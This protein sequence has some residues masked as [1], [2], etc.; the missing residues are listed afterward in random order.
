MVQHYW[1]SMTS[2]KSAEN[3]TKRVAVVVV[4]GIA[5]QKPNES[6]QAI[7]NLLQHKWSPYPGF[8]P[9]RTLGEEEI[10]IP[11]RKI[12]VDSADLEKF[13]ASSSRFWNPILELIRLSERFF[14][15][16][17]QEFNQSLDALKVHVS[18][19]FKSKKSARRS[20]KEAH[21]KGHQILD[22][23]H[24]FTRDQ[25][26]KYVVKKDYEY[27][28]SIRVK[29][30]Q[31]VSAE[32]VQID[33]HEM[34]WADL[35]RVGKGFINVFGKF[36]QLLF[37]I[38]SL[39]RQCIDF[40]RYEDLKRADIT[41]QKADQ[42][43]KQALEQK[44]YQKLEREIQK[45]KFWMN[46]QQRLWWFYSAVQAIAGR[47]LTLVIPILN[48]FV[49]VAGLASL[50]GLIPYPDP[51]FPPTPPVTP[52][53][54]L[55]PWI[56]IGGMCLVLFATIGNRVLTRNRL[57]PQ[58]WATLFLFGVGIPAILGSAYLN[59]HLLTERFFILCLYQTLA[60]VWSVVLIYLLVKIL[61]IPYNKHRKGVIGMTTI[62]GFITAIAGFWC[63]FSASSS[64]D[65][66]SRHHDVLVLGSLKLIE[67]L[68]LELFLAWAAFLLLY[69][70]SF[71]LGFVTLLLN[72]CI[73]TS[74]CHHQRPTFWTLYR[75]TWTARLSLTLPAILFSFL[76]LSLW[77]AI[78]SPQVGGMVLPNRAFYQ[79]L[80]LFQLSTSITPQSFITC[81]T[82]FS[83]SAV[84]LLIVSAVAILL[85]LTVWA[86]L[87]SFWTEYK[88][89]QKSEELFTQGLGNWLTS[90]YMLVIIGIEIILNLGIPLL[91]IVGTT[92]GAYQLLGLQLPQILR[93]LSDGTAC[94]V[95]DS[96]TTANLLNWVAGILVASA[97]GLI[98]FGNRLDILAG[99]VQNILDL[100]LDVDNYLRSRPEDDTPTGRIFARYY[101]LLKFLH[102]QKGKKQYDAIVIIAHSQ[103]TAISADLL[104]FLKQE[105]NCFGKEYS[106]KR[107]EPR[108]EA[109]PPLPIYLF[110][111]GSPL[112]QLYSFGFPQLYS[113]VLNDYMEPRKS[114]AARLQPDPSELL[115]VQKWVN[116]YRSGDYVGRFIQN[117]VTMRDQWWKMA[118]N[119]NNVRKRIRQT[120]SLI[121]FCIG[122]GA[123]NHYWNETAPLI[124]VALDELI[125]GALC[126][127]LSETFYTGSE[128]TEFRQISGTG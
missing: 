65:L 41:L 114:N 7:A 101:S 103:G 104:R 19:H 82:V 60:F 110:T 61:L 112:Q 107:L 44:T 125:R 98:A 16:R 81:L 54:P 92:L 9:Y 64:L 106:L 34:Y 40:A 91:F 96:N 48:L 23:D 73:P 62:L 13:E 115:A 8:T 18:G 75:T 79:P 24:L 5:D 102:D 74:L 119:D 100:V 32:T 4:H 111:M 69:A 25:L 93:L 85:G 71:L 3:P 20:A 30:L 128:T 37:H 70:I 10:N 53:P 12:D 84:S 52:D 117:D 36:Y 15:E 90:G 58:W 29:S 63:L 42:E 49:L 57:L 33:I 31:K 77:S 95:P 120:T 113:W 124:A 83:G 38:V 108:D 43:K 55:L 80:F 76:T 14:D 109:I 122:A 27:Y 56:L 66:P 99:K 116:A 21:Y 68:Y 51:L 123:H 78:A 45:L 35:S 26:S 6:A 127:R 22:S 17:G 39:G 11:V 89:I 28:N 72:F 121:E 97:S 86:F 118:E 67:F 47:I 2:M 87:P 88:S 1:C 94:P 105:R 126:D 46:C 50:P 59:Q